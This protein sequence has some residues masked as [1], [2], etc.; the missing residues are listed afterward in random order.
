MAADQEI[1][2]LLGL[3]RDRTAY[4]NPLF[5]AVSQMAYRGLPAYAREGTQLSGTLSNHPPAASQGGGIGIGG[6]LGAAGLG[7]LAGNALSGGGG[8]LG[9]LIASLAKLLRGKGGRDTVQGDQP[10]PGG[11]LMGPPAFDP[12]RFMGWPSDRNLGPVK[13]L[14]PNV[15][16]S[17]TFALP[18]SNNP[19]GN[20]SNDPFGNPFLPSSD[21]FSPYGPMSYP[22]DPSGGSGIGPGM[23]RY[24][25]G[26]SGDS[27]PDDDW[28]HP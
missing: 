2:Q 27:G 26:A 28:W 24:Y 25:G 20:P 9:K 17:E 4:Q 16:T 21:P 13:P 5:Q 18:D 1:A 3:A 8:E 12:T 23:Q 19:F 7:A 14:T 10:F 6:A 22:S 15:T 11:A